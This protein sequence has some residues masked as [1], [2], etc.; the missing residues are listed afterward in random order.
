MI[1]EDILDKAELDDSDILFKMARKY[2]LG[3]EV[4]K[5]LEKA[6][7]FYQKASE[8]GHL[9]AMFNLAVSYVHG[10]G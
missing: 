10:E 9:D 4:E 2:E 1:E 3:I 5:S 7:E 6:I 8:L